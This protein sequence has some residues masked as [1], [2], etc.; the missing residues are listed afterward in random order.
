M[1]ASNFSIGKVASGIAVGA[2]A[3]LQLAEPS[4]G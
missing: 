2:P 1:N 4:P 3:V